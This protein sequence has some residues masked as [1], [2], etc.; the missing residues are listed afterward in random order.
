LIIWSPHLSV[1]AWSSAGWHTVAGRALN[2]W[3]LALR[4]A[5]LVFI[6]PPFS[7]LAWLL[8]ESKSINNNG[9]QRMVTLIMALAFVVEPPFSALARRLADVDTVFSV[10]NSGLTADRGACMIIWTE[11]FTILARLIA[12]GNTVLGALYPEAFTL[13]LALAIVLIEELTGLAWLFA[14]QH[15]ICCL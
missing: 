2:P 4:L 15:S 3:T 8:A 7:G 6:S 12:G 1:G 5:A 10:C 9:N 13:I 11:V 14:H